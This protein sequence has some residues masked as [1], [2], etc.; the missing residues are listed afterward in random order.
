M[1]SSNEQALLIVHIELALQIYTKKI[2]NDLHLKTVIQC[3]QCRHTMS[4]GT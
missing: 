1:Q 2:N 4:W 3:A